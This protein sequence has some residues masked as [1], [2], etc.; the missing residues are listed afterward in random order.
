[1]RKLAV[2]LAVG[3][4]QLPTSFYLK[5][6]RKTGTETLGAGGFAEVY[7]GE[8][9][10][11]KV[12]LK[13]LRVEAKPSMSERK[14]QF[15]RESIMWQKLDHVHI[16]PFWGVSDDAFQFTVCMVLPWQRNGNVKQYMSDQRKNNK[17]SGQVFLHQTALGLDYLHD[18]GIVHGDIHGGNLLIDE[19]GSIRL[20]DFGLGVIAEAT[21]H[22][23]GSTHGGGAPEYRAPE[24]LDPEQFEQENARPT[25][26][27]DVY[28]FGCL[29]V[30]LYTEKTPFYGDPTITG[31]ESYHRLWA[32]VVSGKR[33]LRPTTQDGHLM[34]D[35]IWDLIRQCWTPQPSQR[36]SANRVANDLAQLVPYHKPDTQTY[37]EAVPSL[38]PRPALDSHKGGCQCRI[39]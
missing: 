20:T 39:A 15:C 33:P 16:L 34:S 31:Q 37:P 8:W 9:E 30:E 19:T 7:L 3:H 25:R 35:P 6:V 14:E 21:P 23:Y 17:L 2:K 1:L 29:S 26:A 28:A 13:R 32:G 22:L 10:G 36:P 5:G 11:Q 12:A 4:S 27:S 18:E 24:L 38:P